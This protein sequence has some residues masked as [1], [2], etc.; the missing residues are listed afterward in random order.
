MLNEVTLV[1]RLGKDAET[2]DVGSTTLANIS[3]ATTRW[4]TKKKEE[5]TEWV[6]VT[7]W[8]PGKVVD[9]LTKGTLVLVKARV[10]QRSWQKDGKTKYAT[11]VHS[12]FVK[13]L[14]DKGAAKKP[15]AEEQLGITD[16]DVPF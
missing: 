6:P 9:Y 1:G 14:G 2:K 16:D 15:N 7:L 4:D 12:N 11:E 10:F 13:L 3:I 5:V 8:N